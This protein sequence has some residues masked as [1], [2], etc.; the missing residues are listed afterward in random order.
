MKTVVYGVIG[1]GFGVNQSGIVGTE[2][3]FEGGNRSG[4][5]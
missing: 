3:G 4:F 1:S 5:K 2:S